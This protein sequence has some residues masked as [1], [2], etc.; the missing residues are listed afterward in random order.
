MVRW[1]MVILHFILI[2][3]YCVDVHMMMHIL[4]IYFF[5]CFL[6]FCLLDVVRVLWTGCGL[7]FW[8]WLIVMVFVV[9]LPCWCFLPFLLI[10]RIGCFG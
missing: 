10:I 6:F 9:G 4:A 2:S 8:L 5:V 1:E 3:I 7:M